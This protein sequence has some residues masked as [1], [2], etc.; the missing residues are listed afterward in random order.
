LP[1]L[2]LDKTALFVL[3]LHFMLG[4]ERQLLQNLFFP[5]GPRSYCFF[6]SFGQVAF[7]PAEPFD[8]FE[9]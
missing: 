2:F 7:F 9:P 5:D 8:S 4:R 3:L 6:D 1:E